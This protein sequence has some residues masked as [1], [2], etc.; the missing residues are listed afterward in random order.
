MNWIDFRSSQPIEFPRTEIA[1]FPQTCIIKLSSQERESLEQNAK[2]I[3]EN[4]YKPTEIEHFILNAKRLSKCFEPPT[5]EL[6]LS[7]L[8]KGFG[9][10]LIEGLPVDH[11]LPETPTKGGA[12]PHDYKSSFIAEAMLILIGSLTGS[13]PFNFRQEGRGTAPLIDNIVPIIG[14]RTQ[15]GAGGFD[16][17]FPFH[18]ESAWHR[19]RPDYL[20]L[21][22]LREADDAKTLIFSTQMLEESEW[23]KQSESIKEWF[24]LKAPDLYV[25][26][27]DMG[28]PMGTAKY[29]FAPP[30]ENTDTGIRLNI[31]FNGTD[32]ISAEAVSWLSQLENFIESKTVG[33]VIAPGKALILNN[34]LTCHTRT[35]FSPSFNGMDRWF[36]RGYFKQDLWHQTP[37]TLYNSGT[38]H[39]A[40]QLIADLVNIGWMDKN[41]KLTNEFSKY[42][43]H[44]EEMK[45]LDGKLAELAAFAFNFTPIEGSRIV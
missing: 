39:S 16:N 9:A 35:S 13:E 10:V 1:E 38:N 34:Y 36:L 26:M 37:E 4:P 15:R 42:V 8:T 27:E 28:I 6:I 40:E 31:N 12:L 18:C 14:L 45:K 20:V 19:K 2:L 43:H 44:P 29:S 17:S 3:A 7:Q 32:C 33:A 22:G 23:M 21:L 25:Q 11:Q 5:K 41:R 24:R 30:L